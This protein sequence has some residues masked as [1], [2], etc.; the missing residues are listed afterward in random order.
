MLQ[1]LEW[2]LLDNWGN[3]ASLIGVGLS[4]L[5]VIFARRASVAAK[6]ARQAVLRRNLAQDIADAGAIAADIC[7]FVDSS[8]YDCAMPF[9]TQLQ[10]KTIYLMERHKGRLGDKPEQKLTSVL[11]QLESIQKVSSK[12]GKSIGPPSPGVAD[13]LIESCRAVRLT[14]TEQHALAERSVEGDEHEG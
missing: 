3:L 13:R 7:N 2:F 4:L 9:C 6:E 1:K 12:L 14:Y 10:T 11:A 8:R 5:S